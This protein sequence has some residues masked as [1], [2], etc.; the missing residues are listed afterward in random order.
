MAPLK[1]LTVIGLNSGTSMDGVDAAI[2]RIIPISS[3]SRSDGSNGH[4]VAQNLDVEM[5]DALLYPLPPE[6]TRKMQS[7]IGAR[8]CSLEDVIRLHAA[9]GEVFAQAALAVMKKAG[10]T[11]RDIDLIGSHGQTMWHAPSMRKFAGI[12]THGTMQLGDTSV[13]ASR[14]GVAVV[15]D[16]RSRDMAKGG[17]GAPLVAFADEVL[18]GGEGKAIGILNIGGIAN[19]TVLNSHGEALMAF[20]TGP[21][22][23]LLDR[24][25]QRLLD[26][27]FDDNGKIAAAGK[28]HEE[29]LAEI[30]ENE[31]FGK[32]PPKT[33]GRELFGNPFAD[34]L[35]AQ[36]GRRGLSNEDTIA[37]LTALTAASIAAAYDRFVKP[38][39]PLDTLV[40]G[41]G[42]AENVTLLKSLS[43]RW[44]G[45]LNLK[46]HEDYGVS[47]KFKEALLFALLAYTTH[48]GIPNNVPRCTGATE[49][50]CLGSITRA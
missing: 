8:N 39:Q 42:G 15:G 13:I 19:L 33:T 25:C 40:L 47:T 16:F 5:L 26:K 49:R 6:L 35:M 1:P 11:R 44:T 50:V 17:Q 32:R 30:L 48:F 7:M 45:K 9:L 29:W 37:T 3:Q 20:D 28:V 43:G 23:V 21:G 2:F 34:D 10:M 31:Y 27:P 18:F 38:Q 14:T 12:A 22:N 36:A 46:R 4:T 24:A 41:G